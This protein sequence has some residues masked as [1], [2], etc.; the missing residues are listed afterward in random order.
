MADQTYA[1]NFELPMVTI[2]GAGIAGLTAAH[3]LIERG[4]RVQVVEHAQHAFCEYECSVGGLA[5]NQYTRVRAPISVLHPELMRGSETPGYAQSNLAHAL[6]FRD[7]RTLEAAAPRFPLLEKIRFDKHVHGGAPAPADYEL[8]EP[9]AAEQA[10]LTAAGGVPAQWG[11]YWDVHGA[12]NSDKI[13]VVLATLR[14]AIKH[15]RGL[16]FP[17]L[18]EA[19]ALGKSNI[20]FTDY[21]EVKEAPPGEEEEA[22]RTFVA[23]ETLRVRILGYTDADGMPEDNR[24]IGYTWAKQV[25]DTLIALNAAE[26]LLQ[27]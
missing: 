25:Y 14:K 24:R 19:I 8:A 18:A 17:K 4:F 27:N 1:G 6:K 11:D 13:A 3:E 9:T 7:W 5:A 26:I 22:A 20:R 23:R 21:T 12:L 2:F 15:Y 16:Y 10:R